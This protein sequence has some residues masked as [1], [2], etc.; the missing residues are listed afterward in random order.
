MDATP[1]RLGQEF[2]GY[3]AQIRYGIER[4]YA[5]LPHLR[6]LAIG[7]T[8]V[9]TG[10]NTHREFG[11]RVAAELSRL[12]NTEFREARNH[13]EAQAARDAYVWASGALN[14]IAASMMKI[15]NDIRL[16]ASGPRTG[17][18]ELLLPALQPG[19]SIM[20]GKVNPVIPEVVVQIAAQ[21]AGNH[22]A[23]TIGGQWGQLD[24][25]VM[26]PLMTRNLLESIELL[27][28]GARVFAQKVLKDLQANREVCEG[29]VERSTSLVTAL[30]PYIGYD[31]AAE[32]AQ[33]AFAERRTVREVAYEMSGL[34]KEQVDEALQPRRQTEPLS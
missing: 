18:G 23:V 34:T 11:R 19:S 29:Y 9:G 1:I 6:E 21:V 30:N 31:R 32:I 5:V 28:S 25:N 22:V 2:S 12:L 20:P 33:K 7:G 8:A 26:K 14:T 16:L 17:L 27:A 15:A 10:L 3:A 24:L 13:F 4:L